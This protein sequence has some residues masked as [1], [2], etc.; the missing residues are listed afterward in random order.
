MFFHYLEEERQHKSAVAVP[1]E[2][3]EAAVRKEKEEKENEEH[4]RDS[5]K[6]AWNNQQFLSLPE[7]E[8]KPL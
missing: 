7:V 2:A 5:G 3:V 1:G 8:G 6:P 4:L